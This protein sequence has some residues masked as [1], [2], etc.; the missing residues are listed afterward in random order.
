MIAGKAQGARPMSAKKA[1]LRAMIHRLR[2][3]PVD[4]VFFVGFVLLFLGF[5]GLLLLQ[6]NAIGRGG[7]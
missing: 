2:V 6:P 4:T 7:R 3:L 5:V 1:A